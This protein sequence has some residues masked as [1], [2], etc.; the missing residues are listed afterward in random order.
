MM[1]KIECCEC[2][3]ISLKRMEIIVLEIQAKI[4]KEDYG[5]REIMDLLSSLD[6]DIHLL[7]D[8]GNSISRDLYE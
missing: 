6:H 7:N 2:A 4:L 3:V 8:A 5:K 1:E